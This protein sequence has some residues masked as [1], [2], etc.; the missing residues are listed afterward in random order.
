MYPIEKKGISSPL[1]DLRTIDIERNECLGTLRNSKL[2][3]HLDIILF[4]GSK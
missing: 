4:V 2:C 3:K 1:C